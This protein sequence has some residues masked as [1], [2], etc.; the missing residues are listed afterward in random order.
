M[1]EIFYAPSTN[2]TMRI[3]HF[4]SVHKILVINSTEQ[5]PSSEA[6][7]HSASQENSSYMKPESSLQCS[8][9]S[10]TGPY[11]GPDRSKQHLPTTFPQDP[12][13]YLP[14]YTPS[15]HIPTRSNLLS[16]HL[17]LYLLSGLS[18]S[19][20]LTKILY[21]FLIYPTR[22]TCPAHLNRSEFMK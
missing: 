21:V 14:I 17:R 19:G 18:P 11:S 15:H 10:A 8:Q 2:M 22:A 9:K 16:S 20:F 3:L 1:C 6:E 13:Y 12:F 4:Q 5:S 7:S